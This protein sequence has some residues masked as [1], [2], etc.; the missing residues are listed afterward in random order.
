MRVRLLQD[1]HDGAGHWYARGRE[2][3]VVEAV[4]DPAT[5]VLATVA[6]GWKREKWAEDVASAAP[7]PT[8]AVKPPK[9]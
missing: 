4:T 8:P 2:V 1:C 6:A 7:A 9:A 3:A 5:E